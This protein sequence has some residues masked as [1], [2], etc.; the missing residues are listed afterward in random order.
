MTNFLESGE[1]LPV[2]LQAVTENFFREAAEALAIATKAVRTG[3][4][5]ENKAV[6][7]AIGELKKAFQ[8]VMDERARIEKHRKT[9]S[10]AAAGQSLDL[11][12]AR[13]EIGRRLAC[14]R[15]ASED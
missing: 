12:S 1:V 6:Q 10:G 13:G 3:D 8:H 5:T 2:D 11:D 7:D 14:L 9:Y 4:G 15:A